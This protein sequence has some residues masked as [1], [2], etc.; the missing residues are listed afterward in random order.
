MTPL[1]RAARAMATEYGQDPDEIILV[2]AVG[3][4]GRLARWQCN[5]PAVRAVI[6]AIREPSEAM[7]KAG[8]DSLE[9]DSDG[10][11]LGGPEE[12]A[13]NTYSRMIDALLE[14]GQ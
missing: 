5:L 4:R 1:E 9:H 6:E 3:T 7:T 10:S 14:E 13:H 2:E 12:A 8:R 11:L